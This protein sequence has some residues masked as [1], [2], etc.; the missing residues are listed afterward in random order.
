MSDPENLAWT[1][2]EL[3]SGL[4]WL[5]RPP[6]G[7]CSSLLF[8][9]LSHVEMMEKCPW[10]AARYCSHACPNS[11]VTKLFLECIQSLLEEGEKNPAHPAFNSVCN[12]KTTSGNRGILFWE[13]QQNVLMCASLHI[14]SLTSSEIR[15]K[16]E[17]F[18][19]KLK[20]ANRL[21]TPWIEINPA[22]II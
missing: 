16:A 13:Q 17:R 7:A 6:A 12:E 9:C 15:V 21:L 20:W 11:Q 14:I 5:C 10:R 18:K 8:F 4:W 1:L 19:G 22:C 3:I 2:P